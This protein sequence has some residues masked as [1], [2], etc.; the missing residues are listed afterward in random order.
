MSTFN[1]KIT[2][3]ED[4]K[5]FIRIALSK[6]SM[7]A[8]TNSIIR[9]TSVETVRIVKGRY[10]QAHAAR[11]RGGTGYLA[12]Q[13]GKDWGAVNPA[14][15]P[16]PSSMRGYMPFMNAVKSYII[17]GGRRVSIDPQARTYNGKSASLIAQMLEKPKPINMPVTLRRLV[18][19]KLLREGKGGYGRKTTNKVLPDKTLKTMVFLPRRVPVWQET[20]MEVSRFHLYRVSHRVIFNYMGRLARGYGGKIHR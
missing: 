3:L 7:K 6:Q 16:H 19:L 10:A 1:I 11:P 13:H 2:G 4:T 17:P 5:R 14:R 9:E 8:L 12:E 15:P 18:Y 20:F